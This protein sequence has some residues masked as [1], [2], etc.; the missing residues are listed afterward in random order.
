MA[1][2]NI[3]SD[4]I[5][6]IVRLDRFSYA[7]PG[8]ENWV[9]QDISL[10]IGP[11]QCH[12]VQGPTG[13][14]KSTL[15]MAMR[16]LLPE[17][18]QSGRILNRLAA[19]GTAPSGC[20]GIVRQNPKTQLLYTSLGADVAFGMENHRVPPLEMPARVASAL[21]EVGLDR[22]FS[23]PV[24]ALSMGQQYRVCIAGLLVMD[25]MVLLLDEPMAQLDPTGRREMAALL[26]RLKLAGRAI[27][28]CDHRPE[29]IAAVVDRFWRLDNTGRLNASDP[30]A[31]RP[32]RLRPV[33]TLANAGGTEPRPIDPA[34]T[35]II[36]VSHVK[37]ANGKTSL[38]LSDLS[39]SVRRGERLGIRGPNGSGKTTLIRALAGMVKASKGTLT[40]L[41]S[42]PTPATLRGRVAILYQDPR[43]QMFETT[44]FDEVAF[45]A[46]RAGMPEDAVAGRVKDILSQ[47]ELTACAGLSPHLLSYG[48]T[49]LVGL[50]AVLAGNPE[51]L[52]LDDPFAGLDERRAQL[53]VAAVNRQ[54]AAHNTTV[55][56]TS[57]DNG[58]LDGWGDRI[59]A[60]P[61]SPEDN[62]REGLPRL[63]T[64]GGGNGASDSLLRLNTGLMLGM[65][66]L[67]SMLAFVA[68]SAALLLA[69]AA[70]NLL[71]TV[72]VCPRPL[73][74]L[75]QGA[76]L[77]FWQAVLVILLYG[78][79][80]G[81]A[82]GLA[83]GVQV[84]GQL[85]M[86]FWPGMIFMTAN[87]QARMVRA[88]STLL[89]PRMAFVA[90][91]CLRFLPLLLGEMQTIREVQ[92]YR[93]ARLLTI[94]LKTP[95]HWPDWLHCLMVPT[96]IKTLS[97]AGD[98]ATA[99]EARD[100]GIYPKRT[101]WPGE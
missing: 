27:L 16:G 89:P 12:L 84:A 2:L 43:K 32:A 69:L 29:A 35:S 68:R 52:L 26:Q 30:P 58:G 82:N 13:S 65:C 60:L 42:P 7:Y 20:L 62:P 74:M 83:P 5:H 53:V 22:P 93:G 96:L 94:D 9:L 95:R 101:I 48:Q 81:F 34:G 56:W 15:L 31:S 23:H 54:V 8:M 63:D 39:F 21:A 19:H 18:R 51:L 77:F 92:V 80:F 66:V 25:P 100:F 90:A 14:G 17:G 87:S 61:A 67:L 47:L 46:R 75:R 98:I 4:R 59:V 71:L 1:V 86:A 44:V 40:V 28:I 91:T 38:D 57:H 85:F 64:S 76:R 11:G 45:A 3:G 97:L 33:T 70:V 49:H 10:S 78:I 41:G 24:D 99:A 6:P 73:K 79:R 36:H 72:T 50:A 88:V 55:V 37:L